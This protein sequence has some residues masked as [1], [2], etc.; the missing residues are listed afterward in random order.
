MVEFSDLEQQITRFH[1]RIEQFQHYLRKSLPDSKDTS[2]EAIAELDTAL[3]ELNVAVEELHIQNEEL[4]VT[5]QELEFE[6]Q[7][8]LELFEFA[9]DGYLVTD[10]RGIIQEANL[11]AETMLDLRR[12]LM[13]GKPLIVFL[14]EADRQ[15]IL[16]R[17]DRLACLSLENWQSVQTV[18]RTHPQKKQ[19]FHTLTHF[20]LPNWE[21]TLTPRKGEPFPAILS[22][23]GEYNSQGNLLRLRW[24]IRNISQ[25][26]QTEQK[27]R[28]QAALLDVA[29]EAIFVLRL[30]DNQILFWNKGAEQIYGWKAREA[31]EKTW[32]ELWCKEV[33]PQL[34]EVR[35]AVIEQGKWQGELPKTTKT[36][37][38]IYVESYWTLM[39]DEEGKPK[40]ILVVESDITQKKQLEAQFLHAQRLESLG[41]LASGI[42]HDLNNILS[43]IMG[44]A[45]LLPRTIPNLE[46][47]HLE[48]LKILENSSK[49]GSE[50]VKQILL[51]TRGIEG[52]RQLVKVRNLLWEVV[53]V[54]E[55]TFPKSIKI[56]KNIPKQNLYLVRADITQLQQV[57]MNLCINARDAMPNGGI[58]TLTAQNRF[59]DRNLA[60]KHPDAN[61][62]H[63]L[64]VSVADTGIGI[65]PEN[66]DRIFEPFFTTKERGKGTGLGLSSV[67]GIVKNHGGF[68]SVD[69]EVG[70]GT[71]FE[72]Y[73]PAQDGKIKHAN[74][75]ESSPSL[76]GEGELL[77]V[78]DDEAAI[79]ETLSFTLK[80]YNYKTITASNGTEAIE[81]YKRHQDEISIVLLDLMMPSLDGSTTILTLKK[82]NPQVKIIAMSGLVSYEEIGYSQEVQ[83]A[84]RGFLSKPFS[85]DEL[86][87]TINEVIRI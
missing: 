79:R 6:R 11:A 74:L 55:Q 31:V 82:I 5:R 62:G 30:E 9:P 16:S 37:R 24:L 56:H 40:S 42:A 84:V 76:T 28:E 71:C 29:T 15:I 27:I 52:D 83:T 75:S 69:S 47:S 39:R 32:S 43:P 59:V 80:S 70:K 81:L 50:L 57:L 1:Q 68:I 22:V 63:Y 78:V 2:T 23:S 26:K 10:A 7:R 17:L 20:F 12:D 65:S 34:Q 21:V 73:L 85:R 33:L 77:L 46:Q 38:E 86:L 51:F 61:I 49:R 19:N 4:L 60:L 87:T 58:L 66:L 44:V 18:A 35:K 3:E 25:Q 36:G 67:F 13:A 54:L 53:T 72:I 48:L 41:S 45:Q 64:V 8:Y 14:T